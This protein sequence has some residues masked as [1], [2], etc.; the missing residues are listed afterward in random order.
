MAAMARGESRGHSRVAL[1]SQSFGTEERNFCSISSLSCACHE[2]AVSYRGY[3]GRMGKC[4]L[5]F[6]FDIDSTADIGEL[7]LDDI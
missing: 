5:A 4:D 2:A 1:F 3:S 7:F 6:V